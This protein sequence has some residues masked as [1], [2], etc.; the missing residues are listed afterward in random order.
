MNNVFLVLSST[1]HL[2]GS[3]NENHKLNKNDL[4]VL[5]KCSQLED[6]KV[7]LIAI[8]QNDDG[9]QL[10]Q[11]AS[12]YSFDTAVRI[13]ISPD[14]LATPRTV[15]K[16]V[17]DYLNYIHA[18]SYSVVFG[19]NDQDVN[20][21][22]IPGQLAGARGLEF[23]DDAETI[24]QPGVYL[25]HNSLDERRIQTLKSRIELKKKLLPDFSV[26]EPEIPSIKL[27]NAVSF[28]KNEDQMSGEESN[29]QKLDHILKE[30]ER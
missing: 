29:A 4:Y 18:D 16:T 7:Q 3:K 30:F 27:V 12:S 25:F 24:Q 22:F 2:W 5:D 6:K 9:Y 20:L 19:C 23:Y 11:E 17:V 15:S 1:I 13:L 26:S 21:S 14:T 10:L 8:V 28:S